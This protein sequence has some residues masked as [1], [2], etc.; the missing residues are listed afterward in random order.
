MKAIYDTWLIQIEITNVCHVGCANCTRFLGHHKRGYFMSLEE[1]EKAIDSLEDFKGGIGIMGGEPTMH[2]KFKEICK[3]L[4][5]KKVTER[6]AIWTSGYKWEEYK[7]MI[8]KTFKKGVYYNDHKDFRQKHQPI[9]VGINEVVEDK[10]IREKLIDKC[11]VQEYWSPSINPKGGFFCEIAAAMDILFQGPGGYKIEPGW[12]NKNPEQFK[13]QIKRYCQKCGG[14]LPL[15]CP[16]N[17]EAS[18][19][20]SPKNY[21]LL[22]KLGSPKVLNNRVEIFDKK[23]SK[24]EILA[25]LKS[26]KPWNYLGEG[27]RK[28]DL[29]PDE[30]PILKASLPPKQ[31]AKSL[32]KHPL[33]AISFA[34]RNPLETAKLTKYGFNKG[35]ARISKRKKRRTE[36]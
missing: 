16:S 28:E 19:L 5:R 34:I 30:I 27:Y 35:L 11:W 36:I 23:M 24:E 4:Q 12:W 8:G 25:L 6:C 31:V 15:N 22:K 26:W 9:L 14:A 17:K 29:H 1:I 21:R 33:E 13:D 2:P 3:L 20:V 32:I 7:K 18:D 10:K